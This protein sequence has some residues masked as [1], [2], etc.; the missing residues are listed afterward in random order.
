MQM[1]FTYPDERKRQQQMKNGR[2]WNAND[3]EDKGER[4]P[5]PR[6]DL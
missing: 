6:L 4:R 3:D 1:I 5:A 2:S